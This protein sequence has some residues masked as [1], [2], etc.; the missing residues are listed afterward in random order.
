MDFEEEKKKLFQIDMALCSSLEKLRDTKCKWLC[1]TMAHIHC[2]SVQENV[3]FCLF[4]LK[5]H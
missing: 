4:D 5:F 3:W 1:C 2:T